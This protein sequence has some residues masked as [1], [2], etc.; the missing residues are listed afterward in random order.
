MKDKETNTSQ[1]VFLFS[2]FFAATSLLQVLIQAWA[3]YDQWYI[4]LCLVSTA[5]ICLAET[6]SQ[7]HPWILS[8]CLSCRCTA[9]EQR[10]LRDILYN[11]PQLVVKKIKSKNP[12]C[13]I[14]FFQW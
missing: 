7:K 3:S 14:Q 8:P 4:N 1:K 11:M 9:K 6:S 5:G 12:T 13:E 2:F 10:N